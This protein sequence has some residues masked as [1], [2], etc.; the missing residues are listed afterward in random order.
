MNNIDEIVESYL[1]LDEDMVL[2]EARAVAY[3]KLP[4]DEQKAMA[5]EKLDT[6]LTNLSIWAKTHGVDVTKRAPK[7]PQSTYSA[8]LTNKEKKKLKITDLQ[9]E[10]DYWL[11]V[12]NLL[13]YHKKKLAAGSMSPIQL[14][15]KSNYKALSREIRLVKSKIADIKSKQKREGL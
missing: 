3:N 4:K 1:E 2:C 9:G 15:S 13:M 5:A 8:H 14:K 12:Q 6:D 10:L 7:V 11:P